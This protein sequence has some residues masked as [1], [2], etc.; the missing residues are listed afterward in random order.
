[1]IPLIDKAALALGNSL[2]LSTAV[3]ATLIAAMALAGVRLASR[4]RAALRHALLAA[5]FAVLLALPLVSIFA[6]PIHIAVPAATQSQDEA[7]TFP[8]SA[9]PQPTADNAAQN[10]AGGAAMSRWA[11]A[12][13]SDLWAIGNAVPISNVLFALWIVGAMG[14]L[15]PVVIGLWQV[16][17][18]RRTALP[19]RRGQSLVAP[20]IGDIGIPRHVE[21][22]L[23]ESVAGPMTCGIL[24]PVILLSRDAETWS[25]EDLSRAIAHELEH[26]RRFDWLTH[27]A[28]RIACT[29]YWFHPLV[30]VV[31]RKLTLEAERSCDDAV[32][33]RSEPTAYAEQLVALARQLSAAPKSPLLAMASRSDLASRVTAV[34]DARQRRGR[35]GG[36]A[37]ALACVGAVLLIVAL[38]PLRMIAAE[39]QTASQPAA[40]QQAGPHDWEKAAGGKMAFDVA[41]VKVNKVFGSSQSNIPLSGEE[42]PP[43]GGRLSITDMQLPYFIDFAYKLSQPEAN[44][45]GMSLPKWSWA[46]RFDVEA[47]APEGTTKD[48][49]RL[50]MRSLLE[51]R[52]NLQAHFE[53]Q[54]KPIF[55]LVLVKPGKTGPQLRPHAAGA[56]CKDSGPSTTG[57]DMTVGQVPAVC[58]NLGMLGADLNARRIGARD[59]SMQDIAYYVSMMG[60]SPIRHVIDK[61]GLTGNF[62]F[63]LSYSQGA[64]KTTDTDAP[65]EVAD[66]LFPEALKDQL[67][68]KLEPGTGPVE[69]LIIDHIEQPTPN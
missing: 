48:Q 64:P 68:L 42:F 14:F 34:L 20:L 65:P 7:S 19:W 10:Q 49:M 5:A 45:V 51:D 59:V 22:L 3:K 66:P 63:L 11:D 31:W 23:H 44:D 21:V 50:M 30:W 27:C 57:Q 41:S 9:E 12:I 60:A 67:G 24:H 28:A 4:S 39:P 18:L 35:T 16:R 15:L 62:D 8:Y 40:T 1:M 69:T 55:D 25:D 6:P 32:L 53:T 13:I 33:S 46:E 43:N 56:P 58:H 54:E 26:V 29:L 61:T 37:V 47:R 17:T 36:F 38:S 2:P 52:F